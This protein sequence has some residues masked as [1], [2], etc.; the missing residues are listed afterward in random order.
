MIE[1]REITLSELNQLLAKKENHRL[2]FKSKDISPNKLQ[3]TFVAFANADGG[4]LYIGIEDSKVKDRLKGFNDPEE[5]N[6][7]FITITRARH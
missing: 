5:V 4:D 7:R 1:E 6:D 3:N 2:D